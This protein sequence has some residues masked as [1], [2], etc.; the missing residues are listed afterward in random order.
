MIPENP[1]AKDTDL[2]ELWEMS[3]R[4]DI[5]AF[6]AQDW[7]LCADD[8]Y[9]PNFIGLDGC[10]SDNPDAWKITFPSLIAYRDAWI[11]QSRQFAAEQYA[12]DPRQVL[13]EALSLADIKI[14]GKTALV[15]KKFEGSLTRLNGEQQR[16]V[17]QSLF[18]LRKFVDGWKFCGFVGY[19]PNPMG[20]P[21]RS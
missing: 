5:E 9:E 7:G 11:Q 14:E 8:F 1:Y 18:F 21:S 4:R 20:K 19:L 10:F 15:Q 12:E 13:Y 16:L 2:H 3:V 17:W 6:L